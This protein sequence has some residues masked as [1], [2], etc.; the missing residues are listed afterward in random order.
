[1]TN[2]AKLCDHFFPFMLV[3]IM[4]KFRLNRLGGMRVFSSFVIRH[5]SFFARG[6][7]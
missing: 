3:N 5:S 4:T 1:M 7:K 2:D 6:A